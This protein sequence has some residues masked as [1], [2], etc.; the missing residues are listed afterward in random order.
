[1]GFT[2]RAERTDLKDKFLMIGTMREGLHFISSCFLKYLDKVLTLWRFEAEY[3]YS[4]NHFHQKVFLTPHNWEVK[5][6]PRK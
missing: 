3:S 1:M 4:Q 2:I 6:L 5:Q